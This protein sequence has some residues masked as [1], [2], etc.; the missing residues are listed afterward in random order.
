MP[1]TI[2]FGSV[3]SDLLHKDFFESLTGLYE[4]FSNMD[5]DETRRPFS[6]WRYGGKPVESNLSWEWPVGDFTL[7]LVDYNAETM[8]QFFFDA[9][10]SDGSIAR[11][12]GGST[13][14][15][16]C[17]NVLDTYSQLMEMMIQAGL[18]RRLGD[19]QCAACDPSIRSDLLIALDRLRPNFTQEYDI[20]RSYQY[21]G[22]VSMTAH[23][24]HGYDLVC[25]FRGEDPIVVESCTGRT[26][27]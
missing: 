9:V 16:L 12:Q 26:L 13:S 3:S 20:I 4:G 18:N 22:A 6:T 27:P 24:D 2:L 11:C 23:F 1:L 5:R 7:H 21:G 25:N 19:L 8:D 10:F 14:L 15:S 17:G